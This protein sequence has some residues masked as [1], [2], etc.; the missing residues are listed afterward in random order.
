[1]MVLCMD[2]AAPRVEQLHCAGQA[3]D[4][5]G[6]SLGCYQTRHLTMS[7]TLP[8]R[9]FTAWALGWALEYPGNKRTTQKKDLMLKLH[10]NR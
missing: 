4:R 8:S 3:G 5:R 6:P 7:T 10:L 9:H 1:M 2:N